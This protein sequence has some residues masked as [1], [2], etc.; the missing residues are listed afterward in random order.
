MR[1]LLGG[2]LRESRPLDVR[3]I[4]SL[5]DGGSE[6]LDKA[7]AVVRN[8]EAVFLLGSTGV[9]KSTLTC[10]LAGA[11]MRKNGGEVE[12]DHFENGH[13]NAVE[14]G[15]SW[16]S[17]TRHVAVVPVEVEPEGSGRGKRKV[18][19]CDTPGFGHT[20]GAVFDVAG[21]VGLFGVI[22]KCQS[23]YP[24]LVLDYHHF[25]AGRSEAVGSLV[26]LLTKI[27]PGFDGSTSSFSFVVNKSEGTEAQR[28]DLNRYLEAG[29]K[30]FDGVV[31]QKILKGIQ[32][33]LKNGKVLFLGS[34]EDQG[35]DVLRQILEKPPIKEP[36]NFFQNGAG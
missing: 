15:H 28:A 13:L 36:Q 27:V 12:C 19:L 8:E 20:E 26:K 23:V 11:K 25:E 35:A 18:L 34:L 32:E 4:Q 22:N 6:Y 9:G 16:E 5:L 24:V 30:K 3:L 14:I 10:L 1:D 17:E 21:M 31:G 33:Q 29:I 2:C 7:K